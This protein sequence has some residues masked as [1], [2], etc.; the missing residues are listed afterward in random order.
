MIELATEKEHLA[1]ANYIVSGNNKNIC[2]DTIK[3]AWDAIGQ[4]RFGS[5]YTVLS[6]AG[7]DT[8]EFIPF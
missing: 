7:L 4:L 5:S 8:R 6:P 2:C 3:E 1:G